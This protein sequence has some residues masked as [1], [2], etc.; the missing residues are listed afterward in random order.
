[1]REDST[2]QFKREMKKEKKR[3]ERKAGEVKLR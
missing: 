2:E 3:C 1:M